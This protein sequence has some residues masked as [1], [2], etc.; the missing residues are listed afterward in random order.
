MR[1]NLEDVSMM[2]RG[3]PSADGNKSLVGGRTGG[4]LGRNLS[5]AAV[6][7]KLDLPVPGSPTTTTR[8]PLEDFTELV[9]AMH[10]IKNNSIEN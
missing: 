10:K 9:R 1:E 2:V 4:T 5:A 3:M 7:I 8:T 6:S